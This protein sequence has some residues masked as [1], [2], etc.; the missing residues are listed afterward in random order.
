MDDVALGVK[1]F[2]RVDEL[3]ELLDSV[4]GTGIDKVYVA[5]DGE[6]T[7]KKEK[8]YEK[9]Y[10]FEMSV[11]DLEYDAGLGYGRQEIFENLKEEYLLIVDSDHR[12]PKNVSSLR[13]QLEERSDL[14]GVSGLL[15][16]YGEITAV[17]HD[18]YEKGNVLIRDT[19]EKKEVGG[20]AGSP[21]MEY[22]FLP[23]VAMF[24]KDCLRD[25]C[26]DPE[27]VIG[28]EHI[29]FYVG[30]MENT[31]WSFGVNPNV[32]FEHYPD[33]GGEDYKKNRESIEKLRRSKEYFLDKWGYRQIVLGQTEWNNP[34]NTY[35]RSTGFIS[36]SILKNILMRTPSF[37]QATL[38]NIRDRRRMKKGK[39]PV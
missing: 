30:H 14:G 31:D 16:E 29:D 6:R 8:L 37:V 26:W 36:E 12:I 25:Y 38:M 5:D 10:P 34:S 23:N 18:L 15:L 35:L 7:E 32:L 28:K 22:D 1:V 24:R 20:V 33:T 4:E 19:R 21:L 27:Y 39:G 3:E 2:K 13:N 11:L 17:C 9:N